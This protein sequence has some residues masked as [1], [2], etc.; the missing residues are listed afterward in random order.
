MKEEPI[1][2]QARDREKVQ[3]REK[4]RWSLRNLLQRVPWPPDHLDPRRK[5]LD[6]RATPQADL[7]LAL[8]PV[9][10]AVPAA[11]R[12][13]VLVT[14]ARDHNR[15][16]A[17]SRET[18]AQHPAVDRRVE[19]VSRDQAVKDE[20][21]RAKVVR[22]KVDKDREVKVREVSDKALSKAEGQAVDATKEVPD[23]D[24]VA[25]DNS[26]A[27]PVDAVAAAAAEVRE[28]DQATEDLH[29]ANLCTA[30]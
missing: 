14:R 16:D 4:V 9:V 23:V 21:V 27:A 11:R 7:A 13:Q 5:V 10:P 15:A 3:D 19:L 29:E 26:R 2:V 1:K 20:E 8:V 22:D 17:H 24:V 28:A 30:K 12:A 25:E 18:N 6:R